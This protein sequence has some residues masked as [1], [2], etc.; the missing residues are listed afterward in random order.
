MQKIKPVGA[1]LIVFPL[2]K[3]ETKTDGGIVAFDYEMTR[4]EI[5]EV[6]DE[7][8][9]RYKKGDTVLFPESESIGK[10]IHYEKRNC[11]WISGKPFDDGG[12][13]WGILTK[14]EK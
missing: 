5:V 6:S 4:A 1:Q 13:V 10:S 3:E 8:T 12:D 7:W 9:D 11:L 2:P 14:E